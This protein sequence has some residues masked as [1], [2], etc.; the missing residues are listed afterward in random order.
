[1]NPAGLILALLIFAD[2]A[3]AAELTLSI[4][5]ASRT[6]STVELLAHPRTQ[7]I[8]IADDVSY[9]RNMR[10]Q[11]VPLA[12]LLTDVQPGDHLQ[13]LAIDGFAA[14]LPAAPLLKSSAAQAWLA[15]ENP[16][17]PW[18]ALSAGK[19]S[20]GP[21]YLVWQNPQAA[22]IGPEQWPF[23]IASIRRL[24]PVAE[25]FPAL[26][27]ASAA[28]PAVQAGFV[29]Y[30]KHCMAC[31]RLNTAGDSQLGPDLNLPHSPTEYFASD[32][33]VAYIRDP[34]SLRRWPQG[35]MPG[36]DQ[37]VLSD[38]ELSQLLAYLRHMAGRKR[39]AQ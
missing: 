37:A 2:T 19:A 25:R 33:L 11:A 10:Y 12:A 35:K 3:Q 24:A 36:F 7:Q 27:P 15:V 34:Q 13:V 23:K 6:W 4:G 14:E 21:F 1:M 8:E 22:R 28:E 30:Q 20:A 16:A 29:Q 31:H 5:A 38:E 32:F 39:S 26:L 18:P 9:K 17:R